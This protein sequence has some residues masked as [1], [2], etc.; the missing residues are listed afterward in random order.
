MQVQD[1]TDR[2]RLEDQLRHL[3]D[4]D[5][6]TGLLNRRGIDRAL[7]QHV[8]RGRRYGAEGALLVLDLDGFKAVNDSL[9][10]A[11]GDELIVTCAAALQNRL[12]ETDILGRLGGDEFAVLLPAEGEAEAVIV[13][14]AIVKV[15]REET[16]SPLRRRDAVRRR[17]DDDERAGP[18]RHGDVRRQAGRARP[19][20]V[21]AGP[22]AATA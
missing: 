17:A 21:H 9:G 2:R 5:P 15:I 4:H 3:A 14:E 13:A 7:A 22:A 20:R 19:L 11:A 10:H 12:R 8:A 16:G 6:L 1:I 18:G